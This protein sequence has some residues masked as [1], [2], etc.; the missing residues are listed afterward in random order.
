VSAPRGVL[1]INLGTPDAPRPPEVRRYLRE[2][3]SDPRVIDLPPVARALLV[4]GWILPTRP[5]R[6]AAAYSKVWSDAGS[7]LLVHGQALRAALERRLGA[8]FSVALGMRYGRPSLGEALRRL[9]ERGVRD[10]IALP[11]FPQYSSAATGS[12]LAALFAEPAAARLRRI[13]ALGPFYDDPG[14][15]RAWRDV[16]A[17]ALAA[18][19]ADHVLFSYHGLPERQIRAA[20]P[21][22]SLAQR[23]GGERRPSNASF[24]QRAG[25]ERRP[26]NASFAQRAGGERRP[27]GGHCLASADCCA[28]P[29]DVHRT[30]Y[31]AQCYATTAALVAALGLDAAR[32]STAFQSRLG[33]TPWIRPYTDHMLPELAAAGVRRL[34]IACPSFVAD[35]LETVEE[36]GIRAREQWRALGGE[37]LLL[38]ECPNAHPTWVEAV[39]RLVLHTNGT[40]ASARDA[41]TTPDASASDTETP[42]T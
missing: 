27:S 15:A 26:S 20:D 24:A 37:E 35:C 25:G 39:A 18:F 6:T 3:L 31:R 16:A 4:E 36:I 21:T 1:L 38:V 19:R 10:V 12:A 30:C 41:A 13:T 34:A 7:P 42:A 40:A 29:S 32:T 9:E 2:F 33:R 23:A 14:F 28:R 8:R 11:L 22:A 5:R 17:P